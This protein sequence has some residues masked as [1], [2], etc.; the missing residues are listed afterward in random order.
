MFSCFVFSQ[1]S[2]TITYKSFFSKKQATEALRATNKMW[3]QIELD[4]EMMAKMLRFNLDFT[5]DKSL[6]Y[7]SESMISDAE[8]KNRKE[9]VIGLFYGL[10]Q[11]YIDRKKDSLVEQLQYAFGTI[12]KKNKASFAAWNLTNETKQIEGYTCYKQPTLIF[13]NGMVESLNGLL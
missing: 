8:N 11:F 10:D 1:Q 12:L 2:G 13:K 7:L 9:Y 3:Y 4:H 5:S 6:F